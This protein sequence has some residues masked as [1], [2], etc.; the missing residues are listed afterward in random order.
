[1]ARTRTLVAALALTL[2]VPAMASAQQGGGMG[3]G[4]MGGQGMGGMMAARNLVEQGSV[5]FLVSKAADLRLT[6]EQS[7]ALKAIAAKWAEDNKEPREQLRPL[8]P[9]QGQGMGGGMG[10]GGDMQAMRARFEQMMPLMQKLVETDEKAMEEALKHLD[11]TQQ[12]T[13]RRLI[14]ERNQPRRPGSF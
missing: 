14:Q 7:T 9:Q 10:G 5:E 2:L 12:A 8:M 13:S 11:E 4:G 1:M 3:R 6:E